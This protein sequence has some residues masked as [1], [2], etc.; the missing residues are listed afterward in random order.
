MDHGGSEPWPDKP[1]KSMAC[2][3]ACI[4]APGVTPPARSGVAARA[5]LPQPAMQTLPTGRGHSPDTG[6]PKA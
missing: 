5:A 2:C 6:P 3:V 4:A 1:M